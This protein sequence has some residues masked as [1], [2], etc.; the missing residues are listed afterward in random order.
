LGVEDIAKEKEEGNFSGR[1]PS[2]S[3]RIIRA[4]T[5]KSLVGYDAWR[6]HDRAHMKGSGK[7][8]AVAKL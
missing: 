7:A 8:Y 4:R 5:D 1:K 2:S 3:R 6:C